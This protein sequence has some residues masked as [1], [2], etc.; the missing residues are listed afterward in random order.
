MNEKIKGILINKIIHAMNEQVK[1]ENKELCK[2]NLHSMQ[3]PLHGGDM[4]F[5]LAYMKN[6]DVNKIA[7]A[8][9]V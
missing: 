5:K 9:G 8:C 4:F 7:T 1:K 6:I 2:N 3:K